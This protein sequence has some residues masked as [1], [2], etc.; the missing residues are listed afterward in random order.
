MTKPDV[1]YNIEMYKDMLLQYYK[2]NP[3]QQ[4]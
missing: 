1:W 4:R 2:L 3:P